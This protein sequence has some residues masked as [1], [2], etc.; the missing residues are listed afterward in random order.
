MQ[1]YIPYYEDH[2]S[3][4]YGGIFLNPAVW[5]GCLVVFIAQFNKRTIA[6]TDHS[7]TSITHLAEKTS[8]ELMPAECWK[9]KVGWTE[10][11]N[12]WRTP[13][14]LTSGAARRFV[15]NSMR[16]LLLYLQS[17]RGQTVTAHFSL[18]IA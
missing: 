15:T 14:Q 2:D 11:Q 9:I 5:M 16:R 8:L 7:E 12:G 4:N 10:Y 13:K 6:A 3:L 18:S 17:C 1:V